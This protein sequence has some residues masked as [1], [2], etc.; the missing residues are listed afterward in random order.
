MTIADGKA[1]VIGLAA[2]ATMTIA[3]TAVQA[4]QGRES[5]PS[6]QAAAARGQYLVEAAG[7]HDCHTPKKMGP[8]GPE[9]DMSRALSGQPGDAAVPPPPKLPPG[10]WI[11]MTTG[12]MTAW[13]GPWG[14]SYAANL[15]PDPTTGL[16][17]WTETMFISAIRNGKHMGTGRPLLPPMP[18]Q[19]VRNM[20]DADL[21]ALFAYLRT[22]KPIKNVVPPPTP[23]AQ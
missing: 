6:G 12:D 18:W 13:S 3:A 17:A 15:T 4:R 19:A 1:V 11:A 21:T 2:A 16:G 23:P 20:T 7:C 22:L 8:N 9:P 14:V 10:P 5:Q